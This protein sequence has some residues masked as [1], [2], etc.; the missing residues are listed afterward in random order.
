MRDIVGEA[1]ACLAMES[2]A[3]KENDEVERHPVWVITRSSSARYQP[4]LAHLWEA[5]CWRSI[6]RVM[7]LSRWA[8]RAS[9]C[10]D[11]T[12]ANERMR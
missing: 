1:L 10:Y 2:V 5:A 12:A 11:T 8:C 9:E 7:K 4:A 6:V 3:N